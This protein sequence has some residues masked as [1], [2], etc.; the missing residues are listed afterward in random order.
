MF[1]ATTQFWA[2]KGRF[3]A[4]GKPRRTKNGGK[5]GDFLHTRHSFVQVFCSFFASFRVSVSTPK[6]QKSTPNFSA[7]LTFENRRTPFFGKI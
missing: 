5:E 4:L 1:T 6:F 2:K 3:G 7:A